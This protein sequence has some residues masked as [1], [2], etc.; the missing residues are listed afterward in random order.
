MD[1][2]G[3]GACSRSR[4]RR[5]LPDDARVRRLFMALV[6]IA[7]VV[8]GASLSSPLPG[9]S[10][11]WLPYVALYDEPSN[12][13]EANLN[14]GDGQAYAALA[15]DP[16]L[17]RPEVFR[18]G[19]EEAAYRAQRP[20]FGWVGWIGSAGQAALV[21]HALLAISVVGF[22]WM[23][24]VVGGALLQGRA[25]PIWALVPSLT[26]GAV[27]TLDW[28]G[29]DALAAGAAVSGAVAWAAD[30]R[31]LAV[32]ML[33]A[34]VLLKEISLVVVVVLAAHSLL[35]RRVQLSGLAWLAVPALVYVGWVGLVWWRLGALPSD[36]GQGRLGAPMVGLADA[37]AGWGGAEYLSA[38]VLLVVG[39]GSMIAAPRSPH[40]WVAAA[41]VAVSVLLGPEV[42][43]RSEDFG[44]VLLPAATFGIIGLAPA[45]LRRA[46]PGQPT[47]DRPERSHPA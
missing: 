12:R 41:F 18:D 10:G 30:R 5:I 24:L 45:V 17:R 34:A 1:A 6:A 42:W 28:T 47:A 27:I 11:R 40:A 39:L 29:P 3:E 38:A 35:V 19:V 25:S 8:V 15:Q 21:P 9:P 32:P 23:G 43:R 44:R 14:Q 4:S 13:F 2:S 16:L 36:A 20:L 31:R 22:V 37:A 26:P 46:K 7:T 33:A